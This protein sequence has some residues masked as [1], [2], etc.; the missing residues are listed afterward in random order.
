MLLQRLGLKLPTILQIDPSQA[1]LF[2]QGG[3]KELV[4]FHRKEAYNQLGF[5]DDPLHRIWALVDFNDVLHTPAPVF[6]G[7]PFFV[8]QAASPRPTGREC[9]RGLQV[10]FFYMQSWL[11]SEVLQV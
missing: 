8:V 10:R 6:R 7:G 1:L 2:H 3:V 5:Y 4:Q 11:F 9:T